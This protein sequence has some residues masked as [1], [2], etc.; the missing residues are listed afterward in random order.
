ME[1]D[2][3]ESNRKVKELSSLM[4]EKPWQ[5][6]YTI[7]TSNNG[8]PGLALVFLA[9]KIASHEGWSFEELN[10]ERICQRFNYWDDCSDYNIDIYKK[11]CQ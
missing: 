1:I 2:E 9:F 10:K 5:M 7:T 11:Y 4:K 6:F 8:T 3:L